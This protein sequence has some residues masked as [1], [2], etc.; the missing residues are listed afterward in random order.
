MAKNEKFKGKEKSLNIITRMQMEL[1]V[2]VLKVSKTN[3]KKDVNMMRT[4]QEQLCVML[5][6]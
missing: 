1:Q 3:S 6:N 5:P 2:Q 4:I